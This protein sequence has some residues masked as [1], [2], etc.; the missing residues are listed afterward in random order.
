M[1]FG[2]DFPPISHAVEWKSLFF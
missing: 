2:I 1:I